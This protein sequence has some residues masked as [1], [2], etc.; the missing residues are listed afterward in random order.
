MIKIL[1]KE[2]ENLKLQGASNYQ[3][4]LSG[5][6]ELKKDEPN[7]DI[8]KA[9]LFSILKN[10]DQY[11][12][13]LPGLEDA[14][15]GMVLEAIEGIKTPYNLFSGHLIRSLKDVQLLIN[16]GEYSFDNT[17]EDIEAVLQAMSDENLAT[18]L[19]SKKALIAAL[20]NIDN[21]TYQYLSDV[22][23]IEIRQTIKK[24]TTPDQEQPLDEGSGD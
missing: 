16:T 23:V 8:V 20:D 17:A 14:K 6:L 11:A 1:E 5:L 7:L 2:L 3:N 4:A 13:A 18:N 22:A 19:E 10:N 12:P 15:E 24:L 21:Y 9:S